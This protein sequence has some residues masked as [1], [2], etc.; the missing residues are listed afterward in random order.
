MD[1]AKMVDEWDGAIAVRCFVKLPLF[2]K[3][4]LKS[5]QSNPVEAGF[6]LYTPGFQSI[7]STR[8]KGFLRARADGAII[9]AGPFYDVQAAIDAVITAAKHEVARVVL[10]AN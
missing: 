4:P 5:K 7:Y 8:E 2:A 3:S 9:I 1:G 6:V 10:P